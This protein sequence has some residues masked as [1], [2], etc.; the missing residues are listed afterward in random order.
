M[1]T[2]E[3]VLQAQKTWADGVIRIGSL[4]DDRDA[5]VKAAEEHVDTLYN[6]QNGPVLFKPTRAKDT[7][8]R[9]N[10]ES[11]VSYFVG[12]NERYAEDT[13]FALEPWVNVEFENAD[14]ILDENRAI[15]MGNYHFTAKAGYTKK[16]EYT[17]GYA[18]SADGSLKIDVHHSSAPFSG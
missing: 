15:A 7:Q 14:I 12:G 2:K 10:K 9:L 4:M 6:F 3:E 11:A 8:F 13:G 5:C 18:K 17:F 1:I 16:V